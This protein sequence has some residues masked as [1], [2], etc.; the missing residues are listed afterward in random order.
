MRML[1]DFLPY[2]LAIT[3]FTRTP[4]T[5]SFPSSV[6]DVQSDVQRSRF[7]S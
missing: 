2:G 4:S 5:L 7:S 3:A 1:H 6:I